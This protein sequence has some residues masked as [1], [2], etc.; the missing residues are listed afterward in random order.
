MSGMYMRAILIPKQF[1][2]I[3]GGACE[4]RSDVHGPFERLHA[5]ARRDVEVQLASGETAFAKFV[6]MDGPKNQCS[7]SLTGAPLRRS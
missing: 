3:Y 2:N 6:R 7:S 4:T 1:L 5:D